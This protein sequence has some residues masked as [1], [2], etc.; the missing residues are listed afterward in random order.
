MT[1][2]KMPVPG[3]S[4]LAAFAVATGLTLATTARPDELEDFRVR[5]KVKARK[6]LREIKGLIAEARRLEGSNPSRARALLR[7]AR[8]ELAET[9][10]ISDRDRGDVLRQINAALTALAGSA[11]ER[12]KFK[13]EGGPLKIDWDPRRPI[14]HTPEPRLTERLTEFMRE[15]GYSPAQ[16]QV[17]FRTGMEPGIPEEPTGLTLAER[18]FLRMLNT[19]LS[20]DFNKTPLQD[21]LKY[22]QE[23]TGLKLAADQAPPKDAR[24]TL[25]AN[26]EPVRVILKKSLAAAG[27]T[28]ILKEGAVRVMTPE[29]AR[30]FLVVWASYDRPSPRLRDLVPKWDVRRRLQQRLHDRAR[31]RQEA[32][33]LID[34][35]V[36]SVAPESWEA[37][38]G[39]G[40]IRVSLVTGALIIRQSEE[41]F[42]SVRGLLR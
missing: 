14:R 21:V 24:V 26:K 29:K 38:G 16:M 3:L 22:L 31:L 11:S 41:F 27:L 2:S 1:R 8:L 7:L 23:K 37:N 13:R 42:Y 39:P 25:K 17:I 20:V 6:A 9:A 5:E 12:L 34:F 18:K 36:T 15:E 28:F 4:V 35:V 19:T 32:K 33:E 10:G 30:Q 40:T